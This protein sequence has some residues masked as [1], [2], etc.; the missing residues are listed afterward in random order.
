MEPFRVAITGCHR[1]L[2]RGPAGHNWAAAFAAV[3]QTVIVAVHDRSAET[4]Q[5]F[6][7]QWSVPAYD[8]YGTMLGQERPEIVCVATR[9]TLHA[10]QIE[11]AVAH[12]AR[13]ILCEK[14][15]AT[16]MSEADRIA[17]ACR[18]S[19]TRF[20]LGLDR[21]WMAF[22]RH[23]GTLLRDGTVGEVR[24][25]ASFGMPNLIHTGCHWFDMLA[26][27]AGDS[28]VEWVAATVDT[29]RGNAADPPGSGIIEFANGARA[30]VDGGPGGVGFDINGSTGRMTLLNDGAETALWTREGR[31]AL[32]RCEFPSPPPANDPRLEAVRDLVGAIR[33]GR[34]TAC[35]LDAALRSLEIGL[36]F[37]ASHAQFGARVGFPLPD[38][39]LQVL[40]LPWGNE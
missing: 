15:L 30:L 16:S 9:Q 33:E 28:L 34:S 31:G 35:D 39:G 11:A 23:V 25:V 17:A 26:L 19:G 4:R 29:T 37:H 22:Y 2:E 36:A 10:E 12:G 38:R 5:R 40:S 7:E 27:L 3:P 24:S 1:M 13:G 32:V 14:P 8:D 18:R 20:A 21:R 6:A